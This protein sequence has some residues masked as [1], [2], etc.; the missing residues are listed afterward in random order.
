MAIGN[1]TFSSYQRNSKSHSR[2]RLRLGMQRIHLITRLYEIRIRNTERYERVK[3]T[4]PQPNHPENASV[5]L[6]E[7][8]C[9]F[10]FGAKHQ[11]GT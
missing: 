3:D 5:F 1:N 4:P 10:V 2:K 11:Q 6:R 8:V 7:I 9:L